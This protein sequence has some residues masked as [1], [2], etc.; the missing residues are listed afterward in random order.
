M[1]D[2][3]PLRA[4]HYDLEGR[5]ASQDVVAPPYDVIDDGQRAAL[6]ARSPYNVVGSTCPEAASDRYARAA[7][8]L[9]RWRAEGV[10]VRDEEPALWALEQRYTGRTARPHAARVPRARARGGLRPRPDPP[11][12]AHA[13][14]PEGGSAEADARDQGQPV[15]DL[16]AV[17]RSRAAPRARRSRRRRRTAPWGEATDDDGT[18][19]RLWRFAD[20]AAIAAVQRRA[21]RAPSC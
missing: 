4:L 11:A 1:A 9:A 10:I 20:P 14:R 19:N 7:A 16:L 17:L 8:L 12:R 6:D 21:R 18:V 2:V 13:S 3:E 15:A 5:A